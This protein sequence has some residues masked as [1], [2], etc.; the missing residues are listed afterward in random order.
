MGDRGVFSNKKGVFSVKQELR[1][2]HVMAVN[3]ISGGNRSTRKNHQPVVND[4]ITDK[5]Y[6]IMLYRVHLAW[7]LMV[8]NTDSIA[9]CTGSY[10][11][12]YHTI[13]TT[14][15]HLSYKMF[16]WLLTH[17][18]YIIYFSKYTGI[19]PTSKI[20]HVKTRVTIKVHVFIA[21]FFFL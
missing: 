7:A 19:A 20:V 12:N 3:F 16:W 13:A 4:W 11:S 15:A 6:H 14:T 17:F 18:F 21:G 9:I 10:K 1:T 5:L 8:I 2:S